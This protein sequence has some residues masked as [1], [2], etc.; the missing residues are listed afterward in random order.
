MIVVIAYIINLCA[1][2]VNACG[3]IGLC[4]IVAYQDWGVLSIA[5]VAAVI[6]FVFGIAAYK[7]DIPPRW[8]WAK[9]RNQI[10]EFSVAAVLGYAYS[11]AA[12]VGFIYFI[13]CIVSNMG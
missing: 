11:F 7:N 1:P 6:G 3:L 4:G 8:F 13:N 10:F 9:S 12:W 2:L 5:G